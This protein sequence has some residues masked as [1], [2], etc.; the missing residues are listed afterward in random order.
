MQDDQIS[1]DPEDDTFKEILVKKNRAQIR[2]TFEEYKQVCEYTLY[3]AVGF[4]CISSWSLLTFYNVANPRDFYD[5]ER[6][7]WE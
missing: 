5:T 2:A 4:D 1:I 3:I 6:E 7:N